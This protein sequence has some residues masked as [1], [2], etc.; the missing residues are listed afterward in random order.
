LRTCLRQ[1]ANGAVNPTAAKL[2]RSGLQ[3][4]AA[5]GNSILAHSAFHITKS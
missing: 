2:Y 3:H 5:W 4:A 1:V